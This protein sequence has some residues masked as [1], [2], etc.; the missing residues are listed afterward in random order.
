MRGPRAIRAVGAMMV[1]MMMSAGAAAQDIH[2]QQ[3]ALTKDVTA[4]KQQIATKEKQIAALRNKPSPEQ[5]DVVAAQ[6]ALAAARTA[7][8]TNPG[9][10][11]EGK[12]RNAE[13]KLKLAQ[14]KYDKANNGIEDLKDEIDHLN[15]QVDAKQRQLKALSTQAAQQ[16]Q[17][18][19]QKLAEERQKRQEQSEALA[20]AKQE[21]E[22]AQQEIQRL[23]AA[24]A[25]QEA[26][27]AGK[28]GAPAAAPKPA[29]PKIADTPKP[30]LAPA[31]AAQGAA[32]KPGAI[33]ASGLVKLNA[34][35]QVLHALQA[36]SELAGKAERGE[37]EASLILYLKRPGSKT[38]NKDKITL[39]AL[40]NGQYRGDAHVDAGSY[41]AVL[42]FNHW[43]VQ[44]SAGESG[45][46]TFLCDYRNK[47]T[48][49]LLVY[50]SALEGTAPQG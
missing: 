18:Q 45:D 43:P 3:A 21:A 4:L 20:R 27:K 11:S 35:A 15:T 48:A 10:D 41:E 14:L 9:P 25:A 40:G 31:K 19:Q 6:Q 36:T 17:A 33:P 49:R 39:R 37:S 26:A 30:M 32:A 44:F 29:A 8:Q 7:Q 2:S 12:V 46:M 34:Q 13:F 1:A 22:A 5:A 16:A 50:P 42:G 28:T 24:L 38:T 47:N 23:K